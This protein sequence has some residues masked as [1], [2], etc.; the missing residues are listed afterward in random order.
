LDNGPFLRDLA[1]RGF[2]V[3]TGSRGSYPFTAQVLAAMLNMAHLPEIDAFNPAPITEAGQARAIADAVRSN[4][5]LAQLERSGYWTMSTGL[6]ATVLTLR[7]VDEYIDRGV[8]TMFEHQVLRRTALW[9]WLDTTW[10]LPQLQS[11]VVQTFDIIEEVA[12]GERDVPVFLFAHVMSPHTPFVFDTEG[13]I[14]HLSCDPMCE[15]WTI[16][17]ERMPL[18]EREFEAAY[19][20]QVLHVNELALGAVDAIV[21]ANP[22]AVVILLSDHGARA[23]PAQ[24]DEWYR[25]FFAARTPGHRGVF[26]DDAGAL[27]VFPTLFRAYF[28]DRIPVPDARIYHAHPDAG[29]QFPLN[30]E[31]GD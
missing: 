20:A 5:A 17:R 19:S 14:P 28:G 16:Y 1:D 12:E 25:T 15:R 2:D 23:D 3:A 6:P 22:E 27:A 8:V 29:L 18:P 13:R 9:D 10:A 26:D 21:R 7:G 24:S 11:Q 4:P 31:R 30:V